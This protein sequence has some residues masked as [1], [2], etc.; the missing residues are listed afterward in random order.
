M[1]RKH[2]AVFTILAVCLWNAAALFTVNSQTGNTLNEGF[3]AGGKTAY[4]VGTVALGSGTWTL[5]D[6]LTGNLTGDAKTGSYSARVRNV[7]KVTMNFNV[8]S[9]G[10]VSV[11]HAVYGTDGSRSSRNIFKSSMLFTVSLKTTLP[12]CLT[13]ICGKSSTTRIVIR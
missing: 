7:G 2:F 3:E 5:D 4:A 11:Q 1:T 12:S 9:A 8:A 6:A 10:T 13:K